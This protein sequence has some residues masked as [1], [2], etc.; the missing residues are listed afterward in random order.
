MLRSVPTITTLRFGR[1]GPGPNAEACRGRSG[2]AADA[3]GGS[4]T[5]FAWMTTRVSR[6]NGGWRGRTPC[7]S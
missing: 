6:W 3:D 7:R 1:R 5:R 2:R 4:G